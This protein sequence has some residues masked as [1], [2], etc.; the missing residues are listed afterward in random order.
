MENKKLYKG[1]AK[2]IGRDVGRFAYEGLRGVGAL[3]VKAAYPVL[4]NLSGNVQGR[5]EGESDGK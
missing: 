3:A 2:E 5:L 4:G 1:M